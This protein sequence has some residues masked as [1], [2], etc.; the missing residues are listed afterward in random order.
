MHYQR[1]V[2]H[3]KAALFV[4][5]LEEMQIPVLFKSIVPRKLYGGQYTTDHFFVVEDRFTVD[6]QY[7]YY[8][9]HVE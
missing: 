2:G 1:V 4:K 6:L 9:L 5:K 7:A 3:V 8:L